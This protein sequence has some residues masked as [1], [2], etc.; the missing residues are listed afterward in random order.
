MKTKSLIAAMLFALAIAATAQVPQNIQN[1]VKSK[2]PSATVKN[3]ACHNNQY[4]ATIVSD[5]IKSKV[6]FSN[7]GAWIST[8]SHKKW[9][10]MPGPVRIGLHRSQYGN[11]D[12]YECNQVDTPQGT[13]Y[14]FDVDNEYTLSGDE[15]P[16]FSESMYVYFTPD[17]N[18]VNTAR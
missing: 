15:Q 17:G 7:N 11:W 5:G 6:L 12:I 4:V 10:Q 3:I 18:M 8:T 13:L 2:Y 14:S 1:A 16:A 9:G